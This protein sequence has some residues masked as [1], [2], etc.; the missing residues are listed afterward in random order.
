[1]GEPGLYQA[2][3]FSPD[4]RRLAVLRNDIRT[5]KTDIWV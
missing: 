4:G 3:A 1:M 5:A 2:P